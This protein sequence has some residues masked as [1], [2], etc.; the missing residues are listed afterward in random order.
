MKKY[1][2]LLWVIGLFAF[3]SLMVSGTIWIFNVC[4]GTWSFLGKIKM[5]SDLILIVCA[6]VA[7]WLWLSDTK[8]NK[9]LKIVLQVLFVIFAVLAVCG[10][11]GIGL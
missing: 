11:F 2:T 1:N 7:G 8:M 10:V 5:V 3:I 4:G 9:T 6:V